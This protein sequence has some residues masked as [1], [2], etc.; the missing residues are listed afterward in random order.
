MFI[1]QKK[2]TI[3]AKVLM[4]TVGRSFLKTVPIQPTMTISSNLSMKVDYHVAS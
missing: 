1:K 2:L 4:N 3:N